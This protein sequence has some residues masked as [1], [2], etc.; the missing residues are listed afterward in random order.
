MWKDINRNINLIHRLTRSH[1]PYYTRSKYKQIYIYLSI[2]PLS[3][4]HV[5]LPQWLCWLGVTSTSTTMKRF[6]EL[7][8]LLV[9]CTLP[10]FFVN[11]FQALQTSSIENDSIRRDSMIRGLLVPREVSCESGSDVCET[12]H[13]CPTNWTCCKGSSLSSYFD[14]HGRHKIW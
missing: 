13:C 11:S 14:F 2:K 8:L 3:A 7:L 1:A 10:P 4:S 6:T 9:A 5:K 12:T